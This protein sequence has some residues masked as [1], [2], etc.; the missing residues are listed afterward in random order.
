MAG[1][2]E[3]LKA[4]RA[5]LVDAIANPNSRVADGG[6][7]VD[8]RSVPELKAA[9]DLVDGEISAMQNQSGGARIIRTYGGKGC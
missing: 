8:K 5:K 4:K 9:L 7:S 3:A 2:L 1:E 6:K